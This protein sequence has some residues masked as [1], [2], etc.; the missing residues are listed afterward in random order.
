MTI[1]VIGGDAAGMSASSRI[2]RRAKD[3]HVIVYEKTDTIS[4]GACGLPFYI[5][6]LNNDINLVKILSPEQA[7][8]TGVDLKLLHEVTAVDTEK[9][10]VTVHD[11]EKDVTFVQ[12][13]DKLMIATGSRPVVPPVEGTDL[14]NVFVL[15]TIPEAEQ[16]KAT[17]LRED[18]R[19][20]A[21]IGGGFI[22]L[23]LCE[24]MISRGKQP[25]LIEAQPHV[26]TAYDE[27]FQLKLEEAVV[28]NGV[29]LHTGE[30]VQKLEGEQGKVCTI[31][32]DKGS[33]EVDA[34]I[35]AIGVRPNSEMF[36]EPAFQKARNGA[37][38]TNTAMETS[39]PD[40]YAAGD[41]AT[42]HNAV[43]G[44]MDYIALGSNANKQGRLA[45]DSMIGK[46]VSFD[47][48]LGTSILRTL[49]FEMGKTGLSEWEARELGLDYGTA[50]VT[51]IS[52]SPYYVAPKPFDLTA[53][54]VYDKKSKVL[55]GAQIMGEREAAWRINVFACAVD[56]KMTTEELGM[57][58]LA[59]SPS[60]TYIWDIIHVVA[61]AA[62]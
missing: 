8:K 25:L 15:K 19:K 29:E 48:T 27:P 14:E 21:I 36:P 32:T 9:K 28:R 5:G 58:D 17:V 12:D 18:I 56:R 6:G 2:A 47:R 37:I 34:V 59:Y 26:M 33:Y 11:L 62:K 23:E 1:V 35:F 61:N 38:I 7:R 40:V 52:H 46:K 54:I 10:Q 42:L 55:L 16:I 13:Y 49:D 50:M 51:Q 39:V 44:K 41:V 20:V 45:G 31:R 4:Y 30:M 53:K 22:G 60:V 3:A 43:T 57:L 24:A